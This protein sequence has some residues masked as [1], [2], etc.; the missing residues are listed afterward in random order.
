M[1]KN[2]LLAAFAFACVNAQA[3]KIADPVPFAKTITPED[4]KSDLSIIASAE[5]G[6][7][8]TPSPGLDKAADYIESRFRAFGL[9]PGNNGSFRQYFTLEK[10]SASSLSLNMGGTDF[11]PYTDFA[12]WISMPQNVALNFSEYIFV[13]YGIVDENRDDY[14]NTDV[15]GKLVIFLSGQPD[16]YKTD[17][18][19]RQSPA[20]IANK[21]L[22]A[23]KKGAAAVLIIADVLPSLQM[24][25]NTYRPKPDA[26]AAEESKA[27]PVF[28]INDNVV[29]KSGQHIKDIRSFVGEGVV[30]PVTRPVSVSITY[31]SGKKT[32][33]VSNVIGMIEGSDKK[34]EYLFV[35]AHYDH[36][37]TDEKGNIYYGADDD[38][39]GTV[40]VIQMA[41][42]FAKAKKAGKG[43]RRTVVFMTVCGE[44]KGL[45]GSE[46][47]AGHP[48]FPVEKTTADLNV[49]MIGRVDTERKSADT[50]NYV[51]VIGHDKLSTDLAKINEGMNNKYTRLVLDYKFDDPN[52][53]NRI[54]YRSDHYNFAK[55]GI[56]ILFFYD[57][58][59]LADYHRPSDTVDKIN[60]P[61]YAKRAQMVFYT[62]WEM[63]NREDMLKR[64]LKLNQ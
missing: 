11:V 1:G 59:L 38:G 33:T 13:G 51:Y 18:P 55:K 3:Q 63:A 17:K 47:Y 36:L 30:D 12:P 53:P 25:N 4:L 6:G 32:A 31:T 8:N 23:K 20:F 58:M 21:I 44:E 37:G 22:N 43:P 10:D 34:N 41:E 35:T 27:I 64:D 57:G 60:F 19:R 9:T 54:Y 16:G 14:K 48:V 61:L 39:S 29:S 49:D 56:P 50:L 28:Y 46:Y 5:M 62:A 45:W 2:L 24:L 42:A 26:A 52:D 7:R 40:S 15:S